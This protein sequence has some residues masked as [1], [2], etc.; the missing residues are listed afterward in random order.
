VCWRDVIEGQVPA[1][2]SG[3]VPVFCS[4]IVFCDD[5]VSGYRD[6]GRN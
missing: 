3:Y 6:V 4:D 2:T 5:N 1:G